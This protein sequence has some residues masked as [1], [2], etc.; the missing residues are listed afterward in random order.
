MYSRVLFFFFKGKTNHF[1]HFFTNPSSV[2][3]QNSC[4]DCSRLPKR[5]F[6]LLIFINISSLETLPVNYHK[7]KKL[8]CIIVILVCLT[9]HVFKILMC[10]PCR[11]THRNSSCTGAPK[12]RYFSKLLP[13]SVLALKQLI[14]TVM[15]KS[16]R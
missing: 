3:V 9:L 11:T 16:N 10:C 1:L 12:C 7:K 2:I 5:T 13:G 14:N 4:C 15:V 8:Y 6:C